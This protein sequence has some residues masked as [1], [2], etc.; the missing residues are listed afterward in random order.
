MILA[1]ELSAEV[2]RIFALPGAALFME[3]EIFFADNESG[4]RQQI[5]DPDPLNQPPKAPVASPASIT[6]LRKGISFVR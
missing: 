3:R 2:M 5:V 1:P 4:A 6:L